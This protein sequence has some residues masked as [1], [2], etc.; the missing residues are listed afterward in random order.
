MKKMKKYYLNDLVVYLLKCY[1]EYL[2]YK[3]FE[4]NADLVK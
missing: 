1:V 4:Y 3:I 2:F